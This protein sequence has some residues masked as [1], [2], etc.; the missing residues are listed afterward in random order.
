MA[1]FYIFFLS[2][3]I[4]CQTEL[5]NARV[6]ETALIEGQIE[7]STSKD[8][9]EGNEL[10]PNGNPRKPNRSPTVKCQRLRRNFASPICV[11][12]LHSNW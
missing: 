6:F 11:H 9:Q 7:G 8:C 1:L 5:N 4:I 10:T 3:G 12:K 2:K